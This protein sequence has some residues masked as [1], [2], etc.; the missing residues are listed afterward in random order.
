MMSSLQYV[1]IHLRSVA[2]CCWRFLFLPFVM[3][4]IVISAAL[5]LLRV[6]LKISLLLIF[7]L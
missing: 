7:L 1:V 3:S 6:V 2:A 5:I 4:K